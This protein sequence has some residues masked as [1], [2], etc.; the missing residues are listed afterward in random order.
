MGYSSKASFLA[1][2]DSIGELDGIE[3]YSDKLVN[4]RFTENCSRTRKVRNIKQERIWL[5]LEKAEL[6]RVK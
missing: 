3:N 4:W 5:N 6:R 2:V 1:A